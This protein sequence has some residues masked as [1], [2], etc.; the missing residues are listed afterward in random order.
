MRY[1]RVVLPA[2]LGPTSAT[3]W[4]GWM[5]KLRSSRALARAWVLRTASCARRRDCVGAGASPPLGATASAHA[6]VGTH[7]GRMALP[8]GPRVSISGRGSL[9][10]AGVGDGDGSL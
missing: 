1:V 10:P 8:V 9:P 7:E 3:S 4:P 2:P 6:C 5:V